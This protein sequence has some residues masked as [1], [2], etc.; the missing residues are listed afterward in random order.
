MAH[1]GVCRPAAPM[2]V[3]ECLC[4]TTV[5]KDPGSPAGYNRATTKMTFIRRCGLQVCCAGLMCIPSTPSYL[6]GSLTRIVYRQLEGYVHNDRRVP[7]SSDARVGIV[8][9]NRRGQMSQRRR[10]DASHN[11]SRLVSEQP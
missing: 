1:H 11:G 3:R 7:T 9:L 6:D 10:N 8:V 2:V 5:D 4:Y